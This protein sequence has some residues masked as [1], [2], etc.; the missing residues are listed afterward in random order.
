VNAA[1]PLAKLS[2]ENLSTRRCARHPEREAAARCPSCAGFFCRE[3]IVEHEGRLLCTSCLARETASAK[4]RLA[5]W[6]GARRHLELAAA[7][8]AAV[9]VFYGIGSILLNVPPEFHEGTIWA[10]KNGS[11]P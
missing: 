4:A 9:L 6:A 5:K 3:C 11:T 1:P 10:P 7:A 2:I 8:L